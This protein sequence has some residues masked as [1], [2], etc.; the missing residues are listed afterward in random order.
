MTF[1]LCLVPDKAD[2]PTFE[3]TVPFFCTGTIEEWI[4]VSQKIQKVLVGLN[5]TNGPTKFS[6]TRSLLRG[7]ATTT[8]TQA[9]QGKT[10]A[11]S[12]SK[13]STMNN[14]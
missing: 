6:I 11:P 3:L 5:V 1:K 10:D 12:R 8:F 4:L 9:L 2:S 14:K 13:Y 7:R